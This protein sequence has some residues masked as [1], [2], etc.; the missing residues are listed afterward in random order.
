MIKL[1]PT[2]RIDKISK[3]DFIH[4]YMKP[5]KPVVIKQLSHDWPAYEKWNL[6]YLKKVAG[7]NIIPLYDSKRASNRKYTYAPATRMQ[8]SKYLDLLEQGEKNLRMFFYNLLAEAPQLTEDFTYPDIGLKLFK[9]L[10]VLFVGG[11][12]AK[13]QMHFDIDLA[14]LLLCHFGGKKRVY[15]FSPEQTKYLYRVPF[16]FSSLFD[17]DYENPDCKKYPALKHLKGEFTELNH[18]EVLYIPSGYWHYVVYGDIGFSISLRAFPR[19]PKAFLT[20]L[21]NIIFV[22]NIDI[23]MRKIVG[24]PWNDRNEK[25]AISKTHQLLGI[26][27]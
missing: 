26:I 2:K 11:K 27:E 10:P 4:Q 1:N 8:L 21:Y 18:G 20:L 7:D 9:R 6:T 15:L 3:E 14:D 19:Q 12:N 17:I 16:S 23:L 22:K 25:N 24:Q 5:Q 13:V